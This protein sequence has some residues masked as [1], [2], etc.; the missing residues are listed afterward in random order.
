VFARRCFCVRKRSR[1]DRGG[2]VIAVPV[3]GVWELRGSYFRPAV[4]QGYWS[5]RPKK[6]TPP[7]L[8]PTSVP[9]LT[10]V[11]FSR[12]FYDFTIPRESEQ[13]SILK[14][15]MQKVSFMNRFYFQPCFFTNFQG[16]KPGALLPQLWLRPPIPKTLTAET[17][18]CS[19]LVNER[20]PVKCGCPKNASQ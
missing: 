15:K 4:I 17:L 12:V 5:Q 6:N 19:A 1:H 11:N 3:W 10:H 20:L 7:L 14:Q 16:K 18:R 2:V 8:F 9:F 13:T